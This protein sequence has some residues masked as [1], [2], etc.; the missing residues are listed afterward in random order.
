MKELK[1]TSTA[2]ENNDFIPAKYTCDGDNINPPLNIEGI[3]N[4][5]KSL[6][7]IVDDPDAPMGIFVHWVVW[8][9]PVTT[10]I[11]ENSVP[12]NEGLN[13]ARRNSYIGPCPPSGTHRYFFKFYALDTRLDINKNSTKQ[14]AEKAMK[15]SIIAKGEIIGLYKRQ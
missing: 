10:K 13:S 12:G 8:N 11:N 15:D 6:V 9:I 2:F 4:N 5:S 7:L 3:P 14:D 1:I